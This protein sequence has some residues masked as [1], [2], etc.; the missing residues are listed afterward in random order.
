[1][2]NNN[3]LPA[4]PGA[5]P[6]PA[7]AA[8]A[9][10]V[11]PA[12][13]APVAPAYCDII[14]KRIVDGNAACY[15]PGANKA[16]LITSL[17]APE[18]IAAPCIGCNILNAC[19]DAQGAVT[20]H[21]AAGACPVPVS[22]YSSCAGCGAMTCAVACPRAAQT[23]FER[24]QLMQMAV[25]TWGIKTPAALRTLETSIPVWEVN[26]VSSEL[27]K[28]TATVDGVSF[29]TISRRRIVGYGAGFQVENNGWMPAQAGE[30]A[31]SFVRKHAVVDLPRYSG[32]VAQAVFPAR[33]QNPPGGGLPLESAAV[34]QLQERIRTLE[35][36]N[37]AMDT[38]LA[39]SQKSALE[40]EDTLKQLQ[41][42]D[43]VSGGGASTAPLILQLGV[44][45]KNGALSS[46][47]V[48]EMGKNLLSFSQIF[49]ENSMASLQTHTIITP[50]VCARTEGARVKD[51]K[52]P[53]WTMQ[54][55]PTVVP[56]N[57]LSMLT[58]KHGLLCSLLD[59]YESTN[60]LP[61]R[62][63]QPSDLHELFKRIC[64]YASDAYEAAIARGDGAMMRRTP[65]S[66]I[67]NE[68]DALVAVLL[69]KA[70]LRHEIVDLKTSNEAALLR[71][72][73][74]MH[75]LPTAAVHTEAGKRG[76]DKEGRAKSNPGAEVQK[77]PKDDV[78]HQ[79]CDNYNNNKGWCKDGAANC[80]NGRKHVCSK[81]GKDHA[82]Y[83]TP[84]C[85]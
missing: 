33:G 42:R 26:G 45:S 15:L 69:S 66:V 31:T 28:T 11:A 29:P 1:M 14:A 30:T 12:A 47:Q 54:H 39:D 65:L 36:A 3:V 75:P 74:N 59:T 71:V 23:K 35:A 16:A 37:A 76:P 19:C 25:A 51:F 2:N 58:T 20:L 40:T 27:N 17:S 48:L 72:F 61:P 10:A 6:A 32:P 55:D 84:A 77:R 81:C 7:A 57:L 49:A 52:L 4:A 70:V 56:E 43:K 5:M 44:G 79:V 73:Q 41:E 21:A 62:F 67:I 13:V 34:A 63:Y 68:A 64:A 85:R 22:A 78:A 50:M 38:R 53:V 83:A 46:R 80:K 9:P 8:A 60:L 24:A 18:H 82:R